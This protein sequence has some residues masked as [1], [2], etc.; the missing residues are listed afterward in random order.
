M[1]RGAVF[2]AKA[3]CWRAVGQ[4]QTFDR[5]T[6]FDYMDGAGELYLAYDFQRILVQE[7]TK[8]GARRIIA[9]VYEMSSSQDAYGV[10]TY[11]PEGE[12]V[13]VGQDNAYA[14]GLLCLW[15]GSRFFRILAEQETPDARTAVIALGRSLAETVPNGPRPALLHRL[16]TNDLETASVR[17]FHTQVS[18]NYFYYLADANILRLSPQTDVA[19]AVYRPKGQKITLLV[20]SYE[21]IRQA[22]EA[23]HHFNRVYLEDKAKADRS[24]RI[25]TIEGGRH[26][27]AITKDR[28]VALVLDAMSRAACERL[29]ADAA[30][31]L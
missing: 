13:G 30:A 21:H 20:V 31:R 22:E 28:F 14:A 27:G 24:P 12:N 29:L 16:P 23:Y 25:K 8:R 18:L 15:K 2:P 5:G 26:V 11:D 3:N 1:D 19:L 4:A 9:E 6:I 10:F 17:Y 7:Y